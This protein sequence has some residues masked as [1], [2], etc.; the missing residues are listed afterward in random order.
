MSLHKNMFLCSDI[1]ICTLFT[2]SKRSIE[3]RELNPWGIPYLLINFSFTWHLGWVAPYLLINFWFTRHLGWVLGTFIFFRDFLF[4]LYFF[5][6]I[7]FWPPL[8]RP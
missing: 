8:E 3:I 4:A 1:V 5:G 2:A 7:D 6:Y